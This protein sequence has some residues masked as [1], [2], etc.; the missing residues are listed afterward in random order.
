MDTTQ[1]IVEFA[2]Q[3]GALGSAMPD[4][5]N[6]STAHFSAKEVTPEAVEQFLTTLKQEASHLFSAAQAPAPTA[7][8]GGLP[9]VKM[10]AADKLTWGRAHSAQPPAPKHKTTYMAT[11]EEQQRAEGK[12]AI[13][14]LTMAHEWQANATGGHA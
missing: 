9:P 12:T 2:S 7:T 13:E 6:R 1:L 3:H 4:V 8:P 10:S 5:L 14:R 11:P